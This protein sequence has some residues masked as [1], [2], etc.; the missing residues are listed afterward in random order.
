MSVYFIL[1]IWTT[2]YSSF[3]SGVGKI[4]VAMV[5]AVF[6]MILYIPVAIFMVKTFGTPGIMMSIILVNTLPNNI[7]YTIQHKKIVNK[8]ATGI[9]N[10]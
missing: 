5:S 1:N 2:P 7:L 9:W 8:T 4:Q 10:K 6:K 3:I